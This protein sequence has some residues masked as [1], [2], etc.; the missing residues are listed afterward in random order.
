ML[1]WALGCMYLFKLWIYLD[2]YEGVWSLDNM[3]A[4]F[5]VY[6]WTSIHFSIVILP[7]Y[8]PTKSAGDSPFPYTLFIIFFFVDFL[9]MVILTNVKWWL[10]IGS[11]CI[12][13]KIGDVKHLFMCFLSIYMYS[14]VKCLFRSFTHF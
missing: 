12:S 11:I 9:I 14:L 3:V 1:L 8:L 6:C 13:L 10:I 4:L 5:S 7:I 2:I